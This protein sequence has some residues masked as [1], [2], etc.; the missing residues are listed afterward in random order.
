MRNVNHVHVETK[1]ITLQP[2]PVVEG[3]FEHSFYFFI[4][5]CR[6]TGSLSQTRRCCYL[7][8]N[9]DVKPAKT[10]FIIHMLFFVCLFLQRLVF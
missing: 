1:R 8:I 7:L 9:A 5:L 10:L 2:Q 3:A 4:Y 6:V